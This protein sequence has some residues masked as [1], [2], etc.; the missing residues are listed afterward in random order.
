M[1]SSSAHILNTRPRVNIWSLPSSLQALGFTVSHLPC[2]AIR[3]LPE[4]AAGEGPCGICRYRAVHQRQCR[5]FRPCTETV[6][7]EQ[8]GGA[9]YRRCHGRS[10]AGIAS[11]AGHAATS[12]LQ[13]RSLSGAACASGRC[14]FVADQG[15]RWPW[16]DH[17]PAAGNGL[18]CNEMDLY[19]RELL[20]VDAT[21]TARIFGDTPPDM[22]SITSNESLD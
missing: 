8:C 2:L 3:D 6:S 20:D 16:S 4:S 17:Q 11:T 12:T 21:M 9:C 19:R 18:A 10:I 22:I 13:Q 14:P 7:M 1:S 15:A 5:T